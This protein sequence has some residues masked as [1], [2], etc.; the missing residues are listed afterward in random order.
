MNKK[1]KV[2]KHLSP[3]KTI[4]LG[5]I[6]VIIL[7]GLLLMLPISSADGTVTPFPD[8]LFTSTSAVCVTGLI[9][10]D[11]ASHWSYFGQGVILLLIQIGGLGVVTVAATLSILAGR[12]ISLVQRNTMQ[13]AMSAPTLGGLVKLTRFVLRMTLAIELLGAAIM[14]PVFYKDFGI[15][16]IWMAIFHSISAFCNAGF[17][18]MGT[19]EAPFVSLTS[20]GGNII[21]APTIM[22]LIIIGGIGFLTLDDILT[23]KQHFIKYRLQSKIIILTTALLIII[24]AI[25][26][27]FGE[28]GNEPIKDRI[29]YSFFQS[30]TPR[31]AGFNTT[32]LSI[33]T[34]TGQLFIIIL[35]LIGG[36]PG[37]TAGGMKTTTI[38]V[39]FANTR[40]VIHKKEDTTFFNRRLEKSVIS[41]ASTILILYASLFITTGIIINKIEGIPLHLCL[42]ETASAC[43]T[44][45]LTLGITTSLG[46][47]SKFIL[48]F[49]MF[50]GR[51]GGLTLIYAALSGTQI[52]YSKLP[53]EKVTVG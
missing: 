42:F 45:G 47:I 23:H 2:K 44:A 12:K 39:L 18:V 17:D 5:F 36:S 33:M 40:A 49:L 48:I 9:V 34:G 30:I 3:F 11:T 53:E 25:Y 19:K 41:D 43:G 28:Y 22:I 10:K 35:M 14:I 20:Y 13:E 37:S 52:S 8:T 15:R 6:G 50:F 31:T 27:F 51:V 7:G 46:L 16:G 24:P 4:I 29:L 26:F 21:V 32:D 1:N 38:A